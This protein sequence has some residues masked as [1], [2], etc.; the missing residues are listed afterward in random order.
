MI[1]LAGG[2]FPMAGSRGWRLIVAFLSVLV[3]LSGGGG[4]EATR[5]DSEDFP[6]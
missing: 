3:V 5:E 1:V 6:G 2:A 4:A